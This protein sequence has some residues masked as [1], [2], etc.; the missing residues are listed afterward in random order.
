MCVYMQI[1][2]WF[3]DLNALPNDCVTADYTLGDD[4][5]ALFE[6]SLVPK[7]NV[8]AHAQI[9]RKSK[10]FELQIDVQG[11]VWVPCD[12]C[13]DDVDVEINRQDDFI[14]KLADEDDYGED[15]IYIN[16]ADGMLD[17]ATLFYEAAALSL[18]V[19]VTHPEGECNKQMLEILKQ[20]EPHKDEETIDPRWE[21][22]KDI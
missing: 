10:Y 8:K 14:V 12:R 4:F 16:K 9:E 11:H 2:D 1:K 18:P 3:L 13:L 21:K 22:L 17:L 6:N 7:G 19:V 20:H 5:W 15:M